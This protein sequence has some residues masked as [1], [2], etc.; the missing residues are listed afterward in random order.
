MKNILHIIKSKKLKD[1]IFSL[2]PQ[3]VSSTLLPYFLL[4]VGFVFFVIY[5]G[6]IVVGDKSAH[7]AK[8]HIPQ[9]YSS[10]LDVEKIYFYLGLKYEYFFVS[11]ILFFIILFDFFD[12]HRITEFIKY[13]KISD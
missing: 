4:L 6:S 3:L 13:F 2:L 12:A 1:L 9:V 11:D 7:Q 10:N 8:L 5:N